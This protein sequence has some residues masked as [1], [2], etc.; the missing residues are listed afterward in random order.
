MRQHEVAPGLYNPNENRQ[1]ASERRRRI[2]K[3]NQDEIQAAGQELLDR[4]IRFGQRPGEGVRLPRLWVNQ[5]GPSPGIYSLRLWAGNPESHTHL[6]VRLTLNQD[7]SARQLAAYSWFFN[8]DDSEPAVRVNSILDVELG[9]EGNG[10]GSALL[11]LGPA[12]LEMV[13]AQLRR[14]KW[15]RGKKPVYWLIRD[16]AHPAGL[17][18]PR[19]LADVPKNRTGWTTNQIIDRPE[20]IDDPALL[21]Q[22]LG[23]VPNH[24]GE[25][26]YFFYVI[27]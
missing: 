23:F 16:A 3:H 2:R 6:V 15:G 24:A 21:L 7:S 27:R 5:E 22:E 25:E 18:V 9:Y 1:A 17:M 10:F 20:F 19:Q 12:V 26:E 8:P 11:R 13:V 4:P 14:Q